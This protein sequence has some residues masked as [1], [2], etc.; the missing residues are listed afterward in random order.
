ML[1]HQC[2]IQA[3]EPQKHVPLL[4][5]FPHH[6]HKAIK[7]VHA[8]YKMSLLHKKISG[9]DESPNKNVPINS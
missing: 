5:I 3:G 7:L 9:I 2:H 8:N 1:Y 4:S 6:Q